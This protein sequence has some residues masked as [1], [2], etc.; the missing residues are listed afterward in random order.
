MLNMEKSLKDR[1]PQYKRVTLHGNNFRDQVKASL[2]EFTYVEKVDFPGKRHA[3]DQM[4]YGDGEKPEY[5]IY[6]SGPEDDWATTRQQFD[7]VLQGWQP[8]PATGG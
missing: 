3:I 7:T 8:K 4:Y 5:A 2:W 6:M 1:L